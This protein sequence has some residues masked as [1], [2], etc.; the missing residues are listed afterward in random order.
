[1]HL[2]PWNWQWSYENM[3]IFV[4]YGPRSDFTKHLLMSTN[5]DKGVAQPLCTFASAPLKVNQEANWF[6]KC[7]EWAGCPLLLFSTAAPSWSDGL[8][9]SHKPK[10]KASALF[11]F[12]FVLGNSFHHL[13]VGP[14]RAVW[15]ILYWI[16]C[17][18]ISYP[19]V[20]SSIRVFLSETEGPLYTMGTN[21]TDTFP[22]D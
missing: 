3:R 20:C 1:M 17:R 9:P 8:N 6:G 21:N 18:D 11:S 7:W 19:G 2:I 16:G 5:T 14:V 4:N 10:V 12:C 13:R 15:I 22:V